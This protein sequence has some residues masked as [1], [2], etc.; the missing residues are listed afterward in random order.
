M[1]PERRKRHHYIP[2]FLQKHFCDADGML[3]YGI[4]D[5]KWCN[6]PVIWREVM[7]DGDTCHPAGFRFHVICDNGANNVM[8]PGLP[9]R[10]PGGDSCIARRQAVHQV[11]EAA[12]TLASRPPSIAARRA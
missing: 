5:S 2:V 7:A 11:W 9:D 3:W 6:H 10:K 1:R 12:P 4:R 8:L